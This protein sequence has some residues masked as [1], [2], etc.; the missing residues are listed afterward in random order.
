MKNES[1]D[2]QILGNRLEEFIENLKEENFKYLRKEREV[3]KAKLGC[4]VNIIDPERTF[5]DIIPM[6]DEIEWDNQEIIQEHFK[7]LKNYNLETID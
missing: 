1:E 5:K 6:L 2:N 4:F 7:E 3:I